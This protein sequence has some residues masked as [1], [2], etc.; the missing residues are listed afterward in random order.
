MNFIKRIKKTSAILVSLIAVAGL[1]SCGTANAA[2]NS[3]TSKV[4]TLQVG[5]QNAYKPY[6]YLNENGEL[7]GYEVQVLKAID[8]ALPQYQFNL[9]PIDWQ[10]AVVSLDT[11]KIDFSANIYTLTKARKAKYDYSKPDLY[12]PYYI[13]VSEDNNTITDLSNIGSAKVLYYP[14]TDSSVFWDN[15]N[16]ENPANKLNFVNVG[17]YGS[18]QLKEGFKSGLFDVGLTDKPSHD[19]SNVYTGTKLVGKPVYT[20]P[21][22]FL[23]S[24]GKHTQLRDDINN[25]LEK[26]RAD[27]TLKKISEQYLKGDYSSPIPDVPEF[28]Y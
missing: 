27:G 24:K 19:T 21:T 23:F 13:S 12:I 16:K 28:A 9:K 25:G 22:G 10:N 4:Q 3:S 26:L 14:S 20:A 7:D 11:G 2:Q 15:Y 1:A 8:E 5:V 17:G 18:E 6:D